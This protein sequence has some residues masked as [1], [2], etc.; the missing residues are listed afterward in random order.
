MTHDVTHTLPDELLLAY[1]TGALP[2]VFDLVV[3]THVSLCDDSR[4]RLE[5]FDAVGGALLEDTAPMAMDEGS[6]AA[7]MARISDSPAAAQRPARRPGIFPEPLRKAV[8]GDLDKVAWRPIG[9]GARQAIL[10]D[11]RGAS[12]RLLS[13]P[14]GAAM[15]DHGHRGLELTLVL[16]GA[17]EDEFGTYRRGDVEIADEEID[18]MPRVLGDETCICLAATS[19]RLRFHSLLP[20]LAQPFL[21]I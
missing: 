11:T 10:Q 13:I 17:F 7:C 6:L 3:A 12:V 19:D 15:P 18:H 8:G 9:M 1:G 14:P 21:R 16:Q 4:A 2:E 20:R 5:S